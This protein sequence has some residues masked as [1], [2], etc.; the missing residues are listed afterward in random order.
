MVYNWNNESVWNWPIQ[1]RAENETY[2]TGSTVG[3]EM[4]EEENS[5][6]A[7]SEISKQRCK[8]SLKTSCCC[9]ST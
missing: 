4:D 6:S 3:G 7:E 1:I 2:S 8:E 9:N 5:G